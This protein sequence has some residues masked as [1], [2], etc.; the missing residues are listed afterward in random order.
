MKA[1][2]RYLKLVEWSDE[3]QCYIGSAPGIIGPCCHGDDEAAVYAELCVIVD[4]WIDTYMADG[5]ALPK[6]TAG[7][8]YSGK[9]VLR[10]DPDLHQRLSIAALQEGKSLNKYCVQILDGSTL[11]SDVTQANDDYDMRQTA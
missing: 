7:K 11:P 1:S 9:F 4:E 6:A 2:N 3:D 5:K 8:V 10:T